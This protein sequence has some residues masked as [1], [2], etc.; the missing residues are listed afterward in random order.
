MSA[1]GSSPSFEAGSYVEALKATSATC[2]RLRRHGGG[3]LASQILGQGLAWSGPPTRPAAQ[4]SSLPGF[5]RSQAGV[6]ST[7]V[8]RRASTVLTRNFGMAW[9]ASGLAAHAVSRRCRAGDH[10]PAARRVAAELTTTFASSSPRG[11]L[12]G[13]LKPDAFNG[14]LQKAAGEKYGGDAPGGPKSPHVRTQSHRS[15]M[16][17]YSGC[18][19]MYSATIQHVGTIRSPAA[20]VER[21]ASAIR[22]VARPRPAGTAAEPRCAEKMRRPSRS[23]RSAVPAVVP[24]TSMV[25]RS[26][27][28]VT[29][30]AA[31]VRSSRDLRTHMPSI[32]RYL[33]I[34]AGPP[35][36][37][38]HL[39]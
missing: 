23:W 17:A 32:R 18:L 7:A 16:S 6:A 2:W 31:P 36:L 11:S 24:S 37:C 29:V 26:G 30:V 4:C 12:A 38:R 28:S 1:I 15:V 14:Y 5:E 22:M 9:G 33:T 25:N 10:G 19:S 13:M 35:D 21:K 34:I 8:P 20:R 27:C 3:T 39:N